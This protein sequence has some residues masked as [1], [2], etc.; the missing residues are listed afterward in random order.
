MFVDIALPNGNE[1]ELVAMARRL[2]IAGL[3]FLYPDKQ[4]VRKQAEPQ[5]ADSDVPVWRGLCASG[6]ECVKLRRDALVYAAALDPAKAEVVLEKGSADSVFYLE[7][8]RRSDSMHYRLS[9]LNQVLCAHARTKEVQIGI[10][11]QPLLCSS[12]KRRA[13]LLGRYGQNI[14]FCRKFKTEMTVASLATSP[15]ELWAPDE[16]RSLLLSLGASA[17]QANATLAATAERASRVSDAH[18]GIL[19]TKEIVVEQ[20]Q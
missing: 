9:G 7:N 13:Q 10:A 14:R 5:C 11:L 4:K 12:G 6:K 2:G 15:W 1:E 8:S 16:I 3:V 18:R 19:R 20:L 17:G